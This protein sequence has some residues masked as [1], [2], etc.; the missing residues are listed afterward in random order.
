MPTQKNFYLEF[1][2][3]PDLSM[4]VYILPAGGIDPQSPHTED[5]VYYIVSGKAQIQVADENR[6][7]QS[8]SIVYVARTWNI[9]STR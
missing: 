1:L 8:G 7:V 9:V 5:E 2:K 3:V 4:G 6:A